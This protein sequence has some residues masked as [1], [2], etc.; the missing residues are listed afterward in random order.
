MKHYIARVLGIIMCLAVNF[1]SSFGA[2]ASGTSPRAEQ[3]YL[4]KAMFVRAAP[5]KLLDLIDLYKER[6]AIYDAAGEVRPFWWR[7]TQGDQWDLMFLFPMGNYTDYYSKER[8]MKRKQAADSSPLTEEAF[9]RAF[10]AFSS[11]REDI[12]VYG[13]QLS[14]VKAAFANTAYYHIEIFISLPGKQEELFKERE[15]ENAYQVDMGRPENLIFTR[16]Q[17]AGW[18]LFTLGCYR[19]LQHWAE[20]GDHTQEQ[21]HAA[22]RKAGFTDADHIGTYMRTLILMHRDTMGVAIK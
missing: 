6:M 20:S 16:D 13:P 11:W 4:Y 21:R 2:P 22:A 17:G 14:T 9:D 3:T 10:D 7:H 18:D 15:M 12:F 1:I 8:L 19:S 5:G